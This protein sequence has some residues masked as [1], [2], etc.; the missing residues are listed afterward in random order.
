MPPSWFGQRSRDRAPALLDGRKVVLHVGCGPLDPAELHEMF[1][2]PDW[3]E[4]RLDIDPGVEP[5]IVDSIVGLKKVKS[6]SVDAVWS[7]HNLEHVYAH[8]VPVVLRAF[9]R[10][11]RPGGTA[12][13]TMPDLQSVA[14]YV[15]RGKLEE[16][17]YE[18]PSGPI[19]A[20]DILYGWRRPIREGNEFMAHKT[21]F[22]KGTLSRKLRDAGFEDVRVRSELYALWAE[23][24][25]P[26]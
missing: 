21:G 12:L 16:T 23:A 13:I 17:L 7:S 19:A 14:Q 5:D 9:H 25:K 15:A 8:E 20:L 3:Q 10:V 4:L 18:V 24:R 1:R 2:G 22:T 11:L 26:V 6:E